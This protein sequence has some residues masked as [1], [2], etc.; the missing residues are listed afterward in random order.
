MP[1]KTALRSPVPLVAALVAL[2]AVASGCGESGHSSDTSAVGTTAESAAASKPIEITFGTTRPGL[3]LWPLYVAMDEGFLK[4]QN[5]SLKMVASESAP[6]VIQT[7]SSGATDMGETDAQSGL[8]AM[9]KGADIE[10]FMGSTNKIPY[11]LVTS[12]DV[13]SWKQLKGKTITVS[14]Q[15]DLL[16]YTF[17]TMA[18][19]A[20]YSPT[21]FKYYYS[22]SS[23]SR[24]AAIQASRASGAILQ[25]PYDLQATNSGMN[26]LVPAY[27]ALPNFPFSVYYTSTAFAKAHPD[28]VK[29]FAA[30][31]LKA[32]DW[33]M[34]PSNKDRADEILIKYTKTDAASAAAGF[35]G[36]QQFKPY[37][38]NGQITQEEYKN[39]LKAQEFRGLSTDVSYSRF[40]D[41]QFLPSS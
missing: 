5:I 32:L 23:P 34:A 33:L 39:L 1:F 29:R 30:G 27:K 3:I 28:A 26:I 8:S 22:P 21:D 11:A 9:G 4:D 35:A 40:F 25:P 37:P 36:A 7:I 20:G 15:K 19:A 41:G 24:F 12:K 38:T 10:A 16:D 31:Y 17:Q 18:K 13:T 2:C 6:A 14:G